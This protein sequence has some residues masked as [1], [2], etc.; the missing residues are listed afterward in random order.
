MIIFA[1]WFQT[2]SK[3]NGKQSKKQPENSEKYECGFVENIAP[4]SLSRDRRIK[5][6]QEQTN[7]SKT[8]LLFEVLLIS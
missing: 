5:M 6:Q 3:L 1:W 8:L 4:P 2:S 7:K